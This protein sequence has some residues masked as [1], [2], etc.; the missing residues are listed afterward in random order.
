M[1]H[2]LKMVTFHSPIVMLVYRRVPFKRWSSS[3]AF[4]AVHRIDLGSETTSALIWTSEVA[5]RC[6]KGN[7]SV[8]LFWD[9]LAGRESMTS[10]YVSASQWCWINHHKIITRSVAR[11]QTGTL[12]ALHQVKLWWN[13]HFSW[14]DQDW[15]TF[16]MLNSPMFIYNPRYMRYHS[17]VD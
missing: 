8:F 10:R 12:R 3:Q 2:E 14:W 15:F 7:G 17:L 6:I 11:Y 13:P 4:Q 16:L 1:V 9:C 5:S